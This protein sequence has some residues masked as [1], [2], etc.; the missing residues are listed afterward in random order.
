MK[1]EQIIFL[2]L[3]LLCTMGLRGQQVLDTL[4]VNG[5]MSVALFFPSPIKR[6]VTGHEGFV[7][8]YDRKRAG[9]VGLLQGVEAED[10]NLLVIT[11]DGLVYA[12]ILTYTEEI[13]RLNYFI[14][15]GEHIG[16]ERPVPTNVPLAK[17][18]KKDRV[19][20][21]EM[22]RRL[23]D[24]APT[25]LARRRKMGLVFRLENVH[26]SDQKVYLVCGLK[27]RSEVDFE[28]DHWDVH[29]VNGSKK[30]R[31]SYQ[32]IPLK[33]DQTIGLPKI[34]AHGDDI[35]FVMVLPKFVLGD[36]ERLRLI[37]REQHGNRVLVVGK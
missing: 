35:R 16:S 26:Y 18:A 30:R 25:T 28:V 7:F 5:T 1:N 36:N 10:S 24:T 13:P 2:T 34:L 23:L 3:G 11:N 20:I 8:S 6:A 17:T 9:H 14:Q 31:A 22:A 37:L 4:Y 33:V 19:V 29:L 21:S 27:N 15:A 32:E 12:Y